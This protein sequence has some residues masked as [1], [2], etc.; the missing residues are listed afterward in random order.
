MSEEGTSP[1]FTLAG[2]PVVRFK[3]DL[4]IETA[5]QMREDLQ[6]A[7]ADGTRI[8]VS[9]EEV[10]YLDSTALGVLLTTFR[11]LAEQKGRLVLVSPSPRVNRVFTVTGVSRIIQIYATLDEALGSFT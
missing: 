5:P 10:R 9:L 7:M 6:N 2:I 3:G 11:R 8:V 1:S 4:D